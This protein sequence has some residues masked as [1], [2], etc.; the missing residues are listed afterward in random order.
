MLIYKFLFLHVAFFS[1]ATNQQRMVYVIAYIYFLELI[2]FVISVCRLLHYVYICL[3]LLNY[4]F[5]SYNS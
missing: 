1:F 5:C 3:S 4:N 2:L